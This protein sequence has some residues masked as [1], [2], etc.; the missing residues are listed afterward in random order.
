VA[1]TGVT[2]ATVG[3][4]TLGD[5]PYAGWLASLHFSPVAGNGGDGSILQTAFRAFGQ[6]PYFVPLVSA[7]WLVKPI[8]YLGAA[9]I[10]I[11]TFAKTPGPQSWLMLVSAALLVAPKGWIYAAPWLVTLGAAYWPDANRTAR[12]FLIA[13]ALL[14][15]LPDYAWLTGQ[16]NRWLTPLNGSMVFWLFLLTWTAGA[17]ARRSS[18][19]ALRGPLDHNVAVLDDPLKA[20][21]RPLEGVAERAAVGPEDGRGDVRI[22]TRPCHPLRVGG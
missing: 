2:V 4:L 20:R 22:R 14:A 17:T 6:S 21:I 11:V 5:D 10:L 15:L 16:P 9:V 12:R 3:I 1:V 13:A 18:R 19:S 7:P 8:W